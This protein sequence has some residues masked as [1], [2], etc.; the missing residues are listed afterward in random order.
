MLVPLTPELLLQAY[1]RGFFPMAEGQG[2]RIYWY[3]PDPRAIF[4]LDKIHFSKRLLRLVRQ[5]RF[6]IRYSSAFEAVIRACADRPST[7]ISE[8]IIRAYIRLYRN[9]Y[10]QSVETWQGGELVGGLYGVSLGGAFFGES[11]FSRV[12]DASKVAFY[13]L[14]ERLKAR[15]FSLL[16][17]QFTNSHLEQFNV[18]EIPRRAYRQ[19]LKDALSTECKFR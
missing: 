15:G 8:E 1:S 5:E 10:G 7:W 14:I 16:D 11:M 19:R 9:G 4:E 6:E 17:T 3:E 12:S 18:V 2:Q 13:H